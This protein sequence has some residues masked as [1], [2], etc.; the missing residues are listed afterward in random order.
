L[1][2]AVAEVA[3]LAVADQGAVLAVASAEVDRE[4]VLVA[5]VL[6]AASAVADQVAVL[7][8]EFGGPA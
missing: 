3:A 4:A 2:V 8:A 5:A 7:A 1:A 6:A